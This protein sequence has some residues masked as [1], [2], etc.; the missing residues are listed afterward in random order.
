M[1]VT[2]Q[3]LKQII[4]EEISKVLSE[5]KLAPDEKVHAQ[6][7]IHDK[8]KNLYHSLFGNPQADKSGE[9]GLLNAMRKGDVDEKYLES[10]TKLSYNLANDLRSVLIE[11][12]DEDADIAD[13]LGVLERFMTDLSGSP[14]ESFAS[15]KF[16]YLWTGL[17]RNGFLPTEY[18]K[19]TA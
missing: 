6:A 8:F 3:Q 17:S 9:M 19:H 15:Q 2:K 4:K 12:R 11:Y 10:A 1:K 14:V 16:G 7:K 13:A 18:Y 5:N